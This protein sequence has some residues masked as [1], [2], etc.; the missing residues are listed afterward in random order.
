MTWDPTTLRREV[1][2]EFARYAVL[3]AAVTFANELQDRLAIGGS[4][5]GHLSANTVAAHR[6]RTKIRRR[7]EAAEE[8]ASRPKRFCAVCRRD[9]TAARTNARTCSRKCKCRLSRL[10]REAA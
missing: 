2:E 10:K 4:G 5:W 9:I 8:R 7:I 3:A 6:E 1:L